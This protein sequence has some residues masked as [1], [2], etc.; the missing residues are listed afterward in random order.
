[1]YLAKLI[2]RWAS[3]PPVWPTVCRWVQ[4]WSIPTRPPFTVRFPAAENCKPKTNAPSADDTA[5][6][7]G[8]FLH[9][10]IWQIKEP[11]QS[12]VEM[13]FPPPTA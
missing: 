6:Q 1:M 2:N 5:C 9:G 11:G 12:P 10:R 13:A 4:A 3:R 7:T 8:R